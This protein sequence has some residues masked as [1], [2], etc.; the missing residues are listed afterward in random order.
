M[1]IYTS[2]K[3]Y[4]ISIYTL[5]EG[6]DAE[7]IETLFARYYDDVMS[8]EQREDVRLFY[9]DRTD[10]KNL[11]VKVYTECSTTYGHDVYMSWIPI[12]RETFLETFHI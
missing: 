3:I 8:D 2:G 7:H 12:S 4:G 11:R 5:V 6:P 10:K 1:G 9:K